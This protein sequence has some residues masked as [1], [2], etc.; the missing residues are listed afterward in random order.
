[1]ARDF[2]I[3]KHQRLTGKARVEAETTRAIKHFLEVA[4]KDRLYLLAIVTGGPDHWKTI[5][6]KAFHGF[7]VDDAMLENLFAFLVEQ[8]GPEP[9]KQYDELQRA[10]LVALK[11]DRLKGLARFIESEKHL[12]EVLNKWVPDGTEREA[13]RSQLL[14]FW[15]TQHMKPS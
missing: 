7:L 1:M 5:A 3:P 11:L 14:L 12:D 8:A 2:L 15:N 9:V 6:R 4:T 10:G 13:L